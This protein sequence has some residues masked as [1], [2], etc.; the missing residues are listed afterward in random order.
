MEQWEHMV[1]RA[2]TGGSHPQFILTPP[3]FDDLAGNQPPSY[4]SVITLLDRLGVE[5]WHLVSA[6]GVSDDG[7]TGTYWL[8]RQ[9]PEDT[10][11]G[12]AYGG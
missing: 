10:T 1:I 8:K 6:D 9:R 11:S 3:R 4:D 12:Y 5:G 2:V 7:R